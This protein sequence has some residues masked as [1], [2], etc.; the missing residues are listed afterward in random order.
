MSLCFLTSLYKYWT[1][2]DQPDYNA[3]NPQHSKP[4]DKRIYGHSNDNSIFRPVDINWWTD[5]VSVILF[6]FF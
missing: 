2:L 5:N 6:L 3:Q 4:S 1:L